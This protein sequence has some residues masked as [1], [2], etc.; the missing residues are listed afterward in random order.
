[1][2]APRAIGIVANNGGS[3]RDY[4]EFDSVVNRIPPVITIPTT[5]GTG[6]EVSAWAVITKLP[7][8]KSINSA[9]ADGTSSP[10]SPSST[11][12]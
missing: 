3:I 7:K 9:P 2:T 4:E 5:A 1:M 6:C 10:A 11:P 8:K 12:R